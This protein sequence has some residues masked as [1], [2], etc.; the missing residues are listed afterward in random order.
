[1]IT[2]DFGNLDH[3]TSQI[4]LDLEKRSTTISY[5]HMIRAFHE[6]H[7]FKNDGSKYTTKEACCKTDVGYHKC[8]TSPSK[9]QLVKF[10]VGIVLYFKFM[11]RL[12][13]FFLLFAIL[14]IPMLAIFIG[15]YLS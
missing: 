1:M 13:H 3:E 12:I 11:K 14:S 2:V 8:F 6:N 4:D 9:S 15:S 10:G 7:A 5:E